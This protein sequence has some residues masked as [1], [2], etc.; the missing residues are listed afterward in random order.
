MLGSDRELGR[1]RFEPLESCRVGS[2]DEVLREG[3]V[4]L[5]GVGH[6]GQRGSGEDGPEVVEAGRA[7]ASFVGHPHLRN[8]VVEDALEVLLVKQLDQRERLELGGVAGE[9]PLARA[10]ESPEVQVHH[11]LVEEGL[12]L[13]LP[14]RRV[15]HAEPVG[16]G[17]AVVHAVGV[18]GT[19]G[20]ESLGA[21]R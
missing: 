20:L 21:F 9:G 5:E 15:L 13:P 3:L 6:R 4:G 7:R 16:D 19:G 10:D 11:L 8:E 14:P 17:D 12:R 1:D 2:G 18:N